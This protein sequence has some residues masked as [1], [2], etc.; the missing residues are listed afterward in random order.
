MGR[1]RVN[2]KRKFGGVSYEAESVE[3]FRK[4]IEALPELV[5]AVSSTLM[6]K[7]LVPKKLAL[8]GLIHFDDQGRPQII[9]DID[10]LT[11]KQSIVL[12]LYA[13]HP[14][15]LPSSEID[16]LLRIS[17]RKAKGYLARINELRH[18]GHLVKE[19]QSYKLT[20][21]GRKWVEDSIIPQFTLV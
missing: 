3:E 2:I 1:Y 7:V 15:G 9:A 8:E 18:E 12:L 5:E 13:T 20:I 19:G 21:K 6:K 14:D 10:K 16:S 17:G 4:G 11:D